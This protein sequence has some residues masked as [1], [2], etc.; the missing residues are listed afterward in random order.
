MGLYPKLI[1]SRDVATL[2]AWPIA[3]ATLVEVAPTGCSNPSIYIPASSFGAPVSMTIS[4]NSNN[5]FPEECLDGV[6]D[7]C[8]TEVTP[9]TFRPFS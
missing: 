7:E 1:N 6:E 9:I 4:A 2:I 5:L 3:I 8:A